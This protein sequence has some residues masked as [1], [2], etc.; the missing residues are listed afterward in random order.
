MAFLERNL[1][2][3]TLVQKQVGYLW[4]GEGIGSYEREL[5]LTIYWIA[6]RPKLFSQKGGWYCRA[7]ASRP[8]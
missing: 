5:W 2:Q 7:Q 6:G 1:E 4:P 3:L 8:K